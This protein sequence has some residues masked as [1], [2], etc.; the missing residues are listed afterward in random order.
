MSTTTTPQQIDERAQALLDQDVLCCDSA[1][2]DGPLLLETEALT[3]DTTQAIKPEDNPR[4]IDS[5]G[6]R[7]AIPW[8]RRRSSR[9]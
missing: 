9:G 1:L 7:A 8:I 2:V 5:L 3:H 6:R 4:E